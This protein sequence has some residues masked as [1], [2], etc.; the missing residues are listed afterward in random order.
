MIPRKLKYKLSVG[1]LTCETTFDDETN[2]MRIQQVLQAESSTPLVPISRAAAVRRALEV[3]S[4]SLGSL[5]GRLS[6]E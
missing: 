4:T 2:I 1:R 6:N 3:Y 5:S